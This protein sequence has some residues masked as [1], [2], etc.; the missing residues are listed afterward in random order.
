MDWPIIFEEEET[1]FH[2]GT[3]ISKIIFMNFKNN[4][5][6]NK[7][8]INKNCIRKITFKHYLYFKY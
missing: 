3:A 4:N 1:A 8:Y 6:Q 2:K 7:K 5:F